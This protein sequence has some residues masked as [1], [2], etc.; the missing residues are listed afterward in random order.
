MW[1]SATAI[2]TRWSLRIPPDDGGTRRSLSGRG[3]EF[4]AYRTAAWNWY[5]ITQ[6]ILGIR[7]G[8]DGIEVNPCIPK[9]WKGFE[10]D[11]KYR[12]ADYHIEVKNPDGVSKGVRKVLLNGKE[13]EGN[14]VPV[15]PA[16]AAIMSR[17]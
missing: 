7:P 8:Y 4:L 6:F 5:A 14:T 16:E 3:K 15:Q 17:S 11:R 10:V 2:C 13:L 1:R 12:G 9:G